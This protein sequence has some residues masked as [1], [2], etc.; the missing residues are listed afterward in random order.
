MLRARRPAIWV[1]MAI[2]IGGLGS[3]TEADQWRTTDAADQTARR[4]AGG[5]HA[6]FTC[7]RC[8]VASSRT[9]DRAVPRPAWFDADTDGGVT[10]FE[11]YSSPTFDALGTDIGQPDGAS[12]LC[13]GC[14]DGSV[15]FGPGRSQVAFSPEDLAL[16]HP[17]SFTYD[18]GLA[19]RV[20]SGAL[21]DP[22]VSP[23]RLGGTIRSDLLDHDGKLQCTS[24]HEVH[25][26][27]SPSHLLRYPYDPQ[28]DG[29][30]T[31]CRVCHNK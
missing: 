14:H 28:H 1:V 11:L 31:F 17:V 22:A 21:R 15:S 4:T 9:D 29:G 5:P 25:A 30:N 23:S 10:T 18:S 3:L 19:A 2:C 20:R 27:A 8:H 26:P 7:A 13:L 12:K 24:C 16:S 6:G